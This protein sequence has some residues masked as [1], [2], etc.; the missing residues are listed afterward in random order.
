MKQPSFG[1]FAV[2]DVALLG[3]TALAWRY[4]NAQSSPTMATSIA[5][6]VLALLS[7]FAAHEWGHFV[8]ARVARAIIYP[9]RRRW[10]P[11]VFAFDVDRNDRRQFFWMSAGG[12]V[13]SA[14]TAGALLWL[15]PSSHLFGQIL[16]WAVPLG[17][18][19]LLLDDLPVVVRVV[20]GAP[21]PRGGLYADSTYLQ[22]KT[23]S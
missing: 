1:Y 3:I 11:F 21:L 16:R 13:S 2:R 5:V 6:S 17:L 15:S 4:A 10:L 8:G 23:S 19:I 20:R 18:L 22:R 7:S 9:A 12:Y 14:L